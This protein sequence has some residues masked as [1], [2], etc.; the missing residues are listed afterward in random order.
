MSKF[1]KNVKS[2]NTSYLEDVEENNPNDNLN[3]PDNDLANLDSSDSDTEQP[4]K[5]K[6]KPK[7]QKPK[8]TKTQK[9]KTQKTT[10]ADFVNNYTDKIQVPFSDYSTLKEIYKH[11]NRTYPVSALFNPYC[12]KETASKLLVYEGTLGDCDFMIFD[13]K[14][15]SSINFRLSLTKSDAAFE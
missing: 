4:S 12:T 7:S 8:T 1:T 15:L 14:V 3:N 6:T 9:P 11:Q 13:G 10:K 2:T 5:T